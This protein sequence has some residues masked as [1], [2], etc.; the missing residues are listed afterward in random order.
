M[1]TDIQASQKCD[2]TNLKIVMPLE[3]ILRNKSASIRT[4]AFR[5]GPDGPGYFTKDLSQRTL[6][7]IASM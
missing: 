3:E 2:F 7:G 1:E 5:N 6:H 4:R